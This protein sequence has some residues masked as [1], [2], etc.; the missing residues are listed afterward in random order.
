M[1]VRSPITV[2]RS[3]LYPYYFQAPAAQNSLVLD[4]LRQCLSLEIKKAIK[5]GSP[6]VLSMNCSPPFQ[7][8]I[9]FTLYYLQFTLSGLSFVLDKHLEEKFVLAFALNGH[10]ISSVCL[11]NLFCL[12]PGALLRKFL[13]N[14]GAKLK[15]SIRKSW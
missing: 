7:E 1:R 4:F 11:T 10:K 6:L 12:F 2:S 14:L 3:S 13:V 5:A 8:T 9:L 15:P